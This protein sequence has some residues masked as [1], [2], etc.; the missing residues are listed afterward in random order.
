MQ[1]V[2]LSIDLGGTKCAGS[3]VTRDGRL[4]EHRK[5]TISG[6]HGNEAGQVILDLLA[7]LEEA[8]REDYRIAGIGVSVPGIA[9]QDS[10]TVWAPNIPGWE[11]Y[12][13]REEISAWRKEPCN[14]YIDSDRACFISGECWKGAAIGMRNA[15]YLAIGTGIGAG[16][17]IDGRI[18]R[19]T[20][21]IAGA[22]GWL[23]LDDQYPEGYLDFGC[24][25][26]NAS[27]EG[28][29]RLAMDL[30]SKLH[31]ETGLR[32]DR[33]TSADIFNAFE[34]QDQLAVAT[35]DKAIDYWAKS[36]ANLVSIFNPEVILFGGGVFGPAE[37]FIGEIYERAKKWAQPLAMEQV[38]FRKSKLGS[39][40][41][42]YGVATLAFNSFNDHASL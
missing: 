39:K 11:N 29:V 36:T 9:R 1:P 41:P 38:D 25:E 19:G 23:A 7:E 35:I 32:T 8:C 30:K 34:V 13:L 2:I 3:I 20:D 33:M 24:F 22:I 4:F 6:L 15:I 16:I 14:I 21:N 10:G 18:L 5:R 42:L 37:K 28:L 26:Y 27:G 17:L 12:P 40:A 31:I